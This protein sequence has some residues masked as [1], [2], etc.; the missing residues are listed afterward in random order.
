MKKEKFVVDAIE[1]GHT[2]IKKIVTAINELRDK[3]G[4][5]KRK[6]EPPQFDLALGL[7]CLVAQFIDHRD[8]CS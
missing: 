8:R 6:V 2:E 1:F 4:K 3:A 5:P 7:A